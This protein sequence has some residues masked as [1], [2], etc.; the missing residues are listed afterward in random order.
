MRHY[1]YKLKRVLIREAMIGPT[2]IGRSTDITAIMAG[3][4]F[5]IYFIRVIKDT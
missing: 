5:T 1:H 3:T 2:L 4:L